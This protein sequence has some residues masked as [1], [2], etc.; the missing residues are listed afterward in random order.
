MSGRFRHTPCKHL[1]PRGP[2]RQRSGGV[3]PDVMPQKQTPQVGGLS[4]VL[5]L[6]GAATS[7]AAMAGATA[8]VVSAW[9][10]GFLALWFPPGVG[11]VP[12]GVPGAGPP[13]VGV[14]DP[15]HQPAALS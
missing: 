2:V 3:S 13:G 15:H 6:V 1:F 10:A 14:L 12:E 9:L 4:R 11:N 8:G 7:G 5:H